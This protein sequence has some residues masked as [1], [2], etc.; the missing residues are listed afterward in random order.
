MLHIAWLSG[1][2]R[3]EPNYSGVGVFGL[4]YGSF[5]KLAGTIFWCPYS[6]DPTSWGTILYYLGYFS[7]VPYLR[8]L[9]HLS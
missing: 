3:T 8:K 6:K 5:G 2:R 7:R 1:V 4:L 9:P